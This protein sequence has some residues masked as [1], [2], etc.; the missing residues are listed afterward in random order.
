MG[1]TEEKPSRPEEHEA[2]DEASQDEEGQ[3]SDR[4][5]VFASDGA[6]PLVQRDYWAIIEG[7]D[8]TP[9]R[10]IEKVRAEFPSFSPSELADF[11]CAHLS[12]PL[13]LGDEME[14]NIKMSGLC[15][16]R[17]VHHDERSF[18]LRT[19]DGHPEAG[20]ITFGASHD[21]AGRL[22]FHIRSRARASS[23]LNYLGYELLGKGMQARVWITFIQRVAEACGGRV[24]GKVQTHNQEVDATLADQGG[25]DTP[26]FV[27]KD[28]G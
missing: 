12:A 28:G 2:P 1:K 14:I 3:N 23:S 6:G 16:V 19:L 21:K 13:S 9:E 15:H 17:V 7:S 24:E 11:S 22:V 8:W 5:V 26:T 18:T 4:D 25:I 10:I 20:R 27:V